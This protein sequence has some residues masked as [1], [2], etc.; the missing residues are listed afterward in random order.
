MEEYKRGRGAHSAKLIRMASHIRGLTACGRF[1]GNQ[2]ARRWA[3]AWV[4]EHV[5]HCHP[6]A[7]NMA[8][9]SI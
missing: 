4:G 9:R 1:R 2:C 3:F 8:M 5:D 6:C 7:T